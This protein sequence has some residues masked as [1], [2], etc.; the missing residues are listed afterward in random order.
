MQLEILTRDAEVDAHPIPLLFV[1]GAWHGAWCWDEH[2]LPY[3]AQHGYTSTALSLRGHGASEGN[4]KLRW[5]SITDYVNDV[6]Q[7]ASQFERPPVLIGHSMGCLVVQKYLETHKAPAA[8]LLAS[9]PP[10]GVI[11]TTLSIAGRHPLPFLKTN[12]TLSLYHII[13]TP[14]LTREAFFSEDIAGEKLTTYY[15]RMQTESYR[16]FL[17]MMVFNLPRPRRVQKTPMLV[18]G[19]ARDII[20]NRKEVEATAR[21]YQTK[22]EIFADMAHDMM[23]EDGWN[24]VADRILAWL[25]EQ[26]L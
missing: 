2:F 21:A 12:A 10:S 7:V 26:G 19:G 3:F 20:F 9:V 18:L 8:V 16:A 5:T 25:G 13:G 17:D 23:L 24:A 6:S 11:R 14:E 22:A 15:E 1:H 4:K